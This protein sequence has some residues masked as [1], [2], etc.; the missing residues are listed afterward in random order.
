MAR[1][2]GVGSFLGNG[3]SEATEAAHTRYG[4]MY[5]YRKHRSSRRIPYSAMA[6]W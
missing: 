4:S 6:A 5:Y 3:R 2:P 1:P